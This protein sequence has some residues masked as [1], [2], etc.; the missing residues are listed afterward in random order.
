MYDWAGRI[1][2]PEHCRHACDLYADLYHRKFGGV[3]VQAIKDRLGCEY[4][5][6]DEEVK[7]SV[8]R[9]IDAYEGIEREAY[10]RQVVAEGEQR[11]K[12]LRQVLDGV[13]TKV[14][15]GIFSKDE[16]KQLKVKVSDIP[17][18]VR[19]Y[20]AL[21]RSE[22]RRIAMVPSGE[23]EIQQGDSMAYESSQ[24]VLQAEQRGGDVMAALEEDAEELLLAIRTMRTHESESNVV[25]F[26]GTKRLVQGE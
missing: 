12:R 3:E 2:D 10:Q 25:Q 4:N 15:Q 1:T 8:A 17:T 9:A 11:A 18:V 14:G 23:S 7:D 5:E 24:R 20:E 26:P 19:G 13:L 6:P 21:E 16:D 22:A